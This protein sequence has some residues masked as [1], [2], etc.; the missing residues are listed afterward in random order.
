[1]NDVLVIAHDADIIKTF[2]TILAPSYKVRGAMSEEE[3]VEALKNDSGDVVAV[4]AEL[5][6]ARQSDYV[7]SSQVRAHSSL[8]PIPLIAIC[9]AEPSDEDMECLE[10]GFFDLVS[11][12][13]PKPLVRQRIGNAIRAQSSLS[14]REVESMLKELPS[15]VFLKD[16][17]GR[18]VFSTQYWR[19]LNTGDDPNWTIRGKTDLDIRKD[20]QNAIKAMEEDRRI[21]ETGEGTEY[22][23]EENQDGIRESRQYP[24]G[25]GER[26]HDFSSVPVYQE[27]QGKVRDAPHC[28]CAPHRG[29]RRSHR[30]CHCC[31]VL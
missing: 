27:R 11:A 15:C 14:L 3:G 6:I 9:S 30:P 23:I 20:K 26:S 12:T 13:S 5:N 1:M 22:V 29:T 17:E 18:Y 8:S 16:V 19:H 4:L 28:R 2:T 25:I 21:I 10:H 31:R 24:C 7:L